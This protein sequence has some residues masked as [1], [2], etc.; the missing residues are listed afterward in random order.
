M[1]LSGPKRQQCWGCETLGY[2]RHVHLLHSKAMGT[3][4]NSLFTLSKACGP[5]GDLLTPQCSD[6]SCF[7]SQ[8]SWN[9]RPGVRVQCSPCSSL[10]LPHHF[11]CLPWEVPSALNYTPTNHTILC[12]SLCSFLLSSW[13]LSY[14]LKICVAGWFSSSPLLLSPLLATANPRGWFSNTLASPYL[15]ILTFIDLSPHL[16]SVIYLH[17]N[18]LDL[19]SPITLSLPLSGPYHP[20]WQPPTLSLLLQSFSP[21]LTPW[22]WHPCTL[23]STHLAEISGCSTLISSLCTLSAPGKLPTLHNPKLALL[24][25]CVQAGEQLC[26]TLCPKLSRELLTSCSWEVYFMPFLSSHYDVPPPHSQ[27]VMWFLIWLRK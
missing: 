14:L 13:L 3:M 27:V 19:P 15:D 17:G 22:H 11:S 18:F 24:Y 8:T 21:I 16:I 1:E 26:F 9:M 20:S 7:F 10:L 6:S 23:T 12:V 25:C 5:T 2:V 4:S